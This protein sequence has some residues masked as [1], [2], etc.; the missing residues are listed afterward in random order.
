[1][2]LGKRLKQI[3]TEKGY[4]LQDLAERSQVSRSM[5][6]QIERDQK[7]PTVNVLCQIAE[8]LDVTVS[9]MLGQDEVR[10]VILIRNQEKP[11]VKDEETGF[12]RVLLSP[13]FPSK[14]IEFV[15]NILP[16]GASTGSFPPH[17]QNVKEYIY[18]AEGK[19]QVTLGERQ[20]YVLE[21]GDTLYFEADVAHR[22]DNIGAGD[23]K[24]FLVIDSYRQDNK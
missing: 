8:A 21:P 13:A 5:L 7:N 14:G 22:M 11:Y 15:L 18:L 23:C 4:T 17:K 1:M 10:D 2:S 12:Q 6:S 3:R 19:L 20:T 24:Y 9:Q 16:E